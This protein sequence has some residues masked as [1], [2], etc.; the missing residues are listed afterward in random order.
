VSCASGETI[1]LDVDGSSLVTTEGSYDV[2]A[3][4]KRSTPRRLRPRGGSNPNMW[5]IADVGGFTVGGTCVTEVAAC[6]G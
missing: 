2:T 3:Q 5:Q 6:S 4:Y 1:V